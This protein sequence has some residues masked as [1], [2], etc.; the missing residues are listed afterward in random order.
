MELADKFPPGF[1][2]VVITEG[3]ERCA[4]AVE[5]KNLFPFCRHLDCKSTSLYWG[6]GKDCCHLQCSWLPARRN[7]HTEE[8]GTF[9]CYRESSHCF[10]LRQDFQCTVDLGRKMRN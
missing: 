6:W 4:V 8:L 7:L 3:N 1:R 2:Y 5:E 9:V 10:C